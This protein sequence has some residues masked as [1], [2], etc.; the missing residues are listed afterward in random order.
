MNLQWDSLPWALTQHRLQW[1]DCC[2]WLGF[3]LWALLFEPELQPDAPL[4][5]TLKCRSRDKVTLATMFELASACIYC[6]VLKR[7]MIF[8]AVKSTFCRILYFL[9]ITSKFLIVKKYTWEDEQPALLHYPVYSQ[10]ICAQILFIFS[11]RIISDISLLSCFL[12]SGS[13]G[14]VTHSTENSEVVSQVQVLYLI[15]FT[16][17][18]EVQILLFQSVTFVK[19]QALWKMQQGILMK[20]ARVQIYRLHLKLLCYVN[21]S[22]DAEWVS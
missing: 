7:I 11:L 8:W 16:H 15:I 13:A 19:A 14:S 17:F 22:Q 3:C 20:I 6:S 2:L 1:W 18:S 21:N 4:G 10:R 12:H 9:A 5:K